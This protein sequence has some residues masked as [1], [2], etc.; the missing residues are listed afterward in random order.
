M[1]GRTRTEE[2]CGRTQTRTV[3]AIAVEAIT[4]TELSCVIAAAAA[5]ATV[6]VA[7]TLV[8]GISRRWKNNF[9]LERTSGPRA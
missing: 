3:S 9:Q 4:R 5:A 8:G 6:A 2:R 7:A 1:D